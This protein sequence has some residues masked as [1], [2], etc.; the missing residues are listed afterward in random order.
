MVHRWVYEQL[1]GPIPAGL[2]LDH[3]CRNPACVRPMHLEPVT[4]QENILRGQGLAA[5]NAVKT[6]CSR[7][8]PYTEANT[9]RRPDGYRDCREC[10][11][12]RSRE[13]NERR[14]ASA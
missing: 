6:E 10:V 11:N 12:L 4:Q 13:R 9:Y 2:V 7:G 14:R 5:A 3:L 8:H 1:V